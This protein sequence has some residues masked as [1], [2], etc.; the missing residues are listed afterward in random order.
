VQQSRPVLVLGE[1]LVDLTPANLGPVLPGQP[2]AARYFAAVPGGGPANIAVGLARLG[3]HTE[4][5]GRFSGSG[6]GPWLREHLRTNGVGTDRC[7]EADQPVT[8]AV[9]ALD[10]D[11]H[12]S[13]TFYGPETAD[14]Q[15]SAAELA[16]L[17]GRGPMHTRPAAVHTGSLVTALAPGSEAIAEWW[18][19]EAG[20][21]DALLSLDPNVRPSLL[22]DA[23]LLPRLERMVACSH[24]VKA[25]D[26]DLAVLYPGMAPLD[27]ATRWLGTGPSVVVVTEGSKG[28]TLLHKDGWAT[29]AAPPP[30]AVSDTIGA[31]DAFTAGFLAYLVE[32]DL[33]HPEAFASAT[34]SA[35]RSC[36]CRAVL[37]GALTC[38]R[39]GAQP[40]WAAE[41]AAFTGTAGT[42][43]AGTGGPPA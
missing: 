6:L 40:P 19:D 41:L 4:F 14:W 12:A 2:A 9:V 8:L 5:A 33:V 22:G 11:G 7:V 20:R 13:Y 31:G 24:V 37:T 36:L 10:S 25:S 15:W 18:Q 34:P 23:S 16:G 28:A 32:Q 27:A 42:G 39:P 29:T 30:V 3:V 38:T 26:D 35:L 21:G 1:C 43:T 17:A